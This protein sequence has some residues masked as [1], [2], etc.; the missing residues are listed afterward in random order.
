MVT[1]EDEPISAL[2]LPYLQD[3]EVMK[4]FGIANAE[5]V[6]PAMRDAERY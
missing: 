6:V 4:I 3:G 5:K 1:W 2:L